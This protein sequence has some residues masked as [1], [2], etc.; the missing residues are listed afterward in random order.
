MELT[1]DCSQ[2]FN[3][4]TS[5]SNPSPSHYFK[6]FAHSGLYFPRNFQRAE[7]LTIVFL[8]F[9]LCNIC[10]VIVSSEHLCSGSSWLNVWMR[11]VRMD[12]THCSREW[13]HFCGECLGFCSPPSFMGTSSQR[14]TRGARERTGEQNEEASMA[15]IIES[16]ERKPELFAPLD[17]VRKYCDD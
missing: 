11:T 3:I 15:E 5:P 10:E 7:L 9:P 8:S 13:A 14:R 2:T 12:K 1:Y 16:E 17:N 6:L 4:L